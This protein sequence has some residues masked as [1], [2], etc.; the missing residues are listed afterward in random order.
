[1]A[2]LASGCDLVGFVACDLGGIVRGRSVPASD[3]DEGRQTSVGWVPSAQAVT[4]LG[5]S[6]EPNPFGSTG[7][8]RL[9]PDRDTRFSVAATEEHSTLD[10][11]LCDLRETD[12]GP[13]DCCPRTLLRETLAEL[14]RVAGV[15]IEASFEQ[16]FQLLFDAPAAAPMSLEAQ[17]VVDPF[18]S[19]AIGALIEAGLEPERFL[20]ECSPHQFEIPVAPAAGLASADRAVALREVVR[21]VARRRG[22]RATFAPLLDPVAQGN[23]VHV[24]FSLRDEEGGSPLYDP[25]RP[26]YLSELGERFAAGIVAHA[27]ALLALTAPSPISQLRLQPNRWSAGAV[28]VGERNRETLLRI[29]PLLTLD[30]ADPAPQMRLEYRGADG[31]A[32]PY[33]V[34]AALVRAGL[35]G[36]LDELP[37]PPI[38]D[39]DPARVAAADADR[40]GLGQLPETLEDSLRA[41]AADDVVRD[42]LP[43]RMLEVYASI[44]RSEI[45]AV[46]GL[47]PVE[48]CRR[49]AQVY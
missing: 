35:R 18:P 25:G 9:V 41:L 10:L 1:M 3:L 39:R 7:D 40:F 37:P 32:N 15:R 47:E 43:P 33:L 2:D 23:G 17:R 30:S 16:E 44:K 19:A 48:I 29:P 26:G 27:G 42:W 31:T 22:L 28:C 8:L 34:L 14:E 21:E 13:W 11:L 45:E 49:Y 4:P 46:A 24:H 12:G 20:A 6:V 38:L 5:P 36:V